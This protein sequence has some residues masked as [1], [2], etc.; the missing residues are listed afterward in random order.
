MAR[1]RTPF[2][3]ALILANPCDTPA[4]CREFLRAL[5]VSPWSYHLDDNPDTIV[6]GNDVKESHDTALDIRKNARQLRQRVSLCN[7]HL[8]VE[9]MWNHYG[10]VSDIGGSDDE[11]DQTLL[12]SVPCE[13]LARALHSML[14]GVVCTTPEA[15]ASHAP[16]LLGRKLDGHLPHVWKAYH[17]LTTEG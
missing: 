9:E 15:L 17:K 13:F 16:R 6:G 4:R 12:T 11:P 14:A 10:A 7:H 3:L 2:D 1:Y 5:A 8:G